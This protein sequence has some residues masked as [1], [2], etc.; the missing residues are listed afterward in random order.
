MFVDSGVKK[1]LLVYWG[2]FWKWRERGR[3]RKTCK[4]E[5]EEKIR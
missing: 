4:K 3:E 1:M 2:N 5:R